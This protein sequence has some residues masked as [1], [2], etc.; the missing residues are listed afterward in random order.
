MLP[1]DKRI[2]K[3]SRIQEILKSKQFHFASPL[4]YFAAVDNDVDNSRLKVICSKKTGNAVVRNRIRRKINAAVLSIWHKIG[5]NIDIVIVAR[6]Y[7]SE[8]VLYQVDILKGMKK[9]GLLCQK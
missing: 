5:K 1:K 7:V 4:F 8:M 2:V 6:S 9:L 3:G